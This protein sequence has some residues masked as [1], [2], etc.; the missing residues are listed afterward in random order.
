MKVKY[1]IFTFS[2]FLSRIDH[3]RNKKNSYFYKQSSFHPCLLGN[4]VCGCENKNKLNNTLPVLFYV[5]CPH[6]YTYTLS[7]TLPLMPHTASAHHAI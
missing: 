1:Y 3:L 2:L 4:K 5:P 6:P 7:F